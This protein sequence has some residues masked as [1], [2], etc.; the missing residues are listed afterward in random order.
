LEK[1]NGDLNVYQT[2]GITTWSFYQSL[3]DLALLLLS[4]L[5]AIAV[6]FILT[7]GGDIDK[8]IVALV[9]FTVGLATNTIISI[10]T[11]FAT[12]KVKTQTS[13]S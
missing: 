10:L 13:S 11:D 4:P 2:I 1:Q 7:R 12:Q 6:W 5:L 8:Y 9:S 3:S